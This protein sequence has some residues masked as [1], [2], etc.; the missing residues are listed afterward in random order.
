V[1]ATSHRWKD[2]RQRFE[3][4][5]GYAPDP[6]A[7]T[8]YDA[9]RVA[10]SEKQ[11][12]GRISL[13]ESFVTRHS[14]FEGLNG[15]FRFLPDGT[16]LRTLEIVELRDDG[17]TSISTWSPDQH[18]DALNAPLPAEPGK[19]GPAAPSLPPISALEPLGKSES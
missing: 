4:T 5:F 9:L 8:A 10:I 7:S 19:I 13:A 18:P 16:N 12:V 11:E 14:G 15:R 17:T 3:A 1:T 6:L 2:F